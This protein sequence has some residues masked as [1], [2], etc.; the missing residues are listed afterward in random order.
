MLSLE[1]SVQLQST[2]INWL[3]QHPHKFNAAIKLAFASY[4]QPYKINKSPVKDILIGINEGN[5]QPLFEFLNKKKSIF[6]WPKSQKFKL[7]D[8]IVLQLFKYPELTIALVKQFYLNAEQVEVSFDSASSQIQL[9]PSMA[10]RAKDQ[11]EVEVKF[12]PLLVNSKLLLNAMISD[13]LHAPKSI[14]E[15]DELVVVPSQMATHS[16]ENPIS[17]KVILKSILRQPYSKNKVEGTIEK[18]AKAKHVTFYSTEITP[19]M[20]FKES[21]LK[22][23]LFMKDNPQDK[24]LR[25]LLNSATKTNSFFESSKNRMKRGSSRR[26][27][28]YLKAKAQIEALEQHLWCHYSD[29]PLQ[30]AKEQIQKYGNDKKLQYLINLAEQSPENFHQLVDQICTRAEALVILNEFSEYFEEWFMPPILS[31]VESTI[32]DRQLLFIISE[33]AEV[34]KEKPLGAFEFT[35]SDDSRLTE[36]DDT[37]ATNTIAE[38]WAEDLESITDVL[39]E[40]IKKYYD[41]VTFEPKFTSS[42]SDQEDKNDRAASVSKSRGSRPF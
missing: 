4:Y 6:R 18:P 39:D 27:K 33:L 23:R 21:L 7:A 12:E 35:F 28:I 26:L 17:S 31:M 24:R 37:T 38:Q 8:E 10:T 20:A 3:T 22:A 19:S 25:D 1:I 29:E 30:F 15:Q 11:N 5:Y 40:H 41:P 34:L 36:V 42:A 2:A 9:S 32:D 14:M 13:L 16:E